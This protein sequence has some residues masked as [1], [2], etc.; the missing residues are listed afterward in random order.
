[1][2]V[3]DYYK[4]LGVSKTASQ[5]EI[6]RAFRKLAR[7]HHPDVNPG[8]LAAEE[9]FKEIN[10]AN[11]VLSDVEKRK[12]YDRFGSQW[13]QYEQTGGQPGDF[14]WSQWTSAR[15]S[16]GGSRTQTRNV[17]AEEFETMFGGQGGVGFSDFFE[18]LF[19]GR[20]ASAGPGYARRETQP[21]PRQGRDVEQPLQVTLSEAFHGGTRKLQFD[22]GRVIE[23][24]IPPG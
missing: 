17:S 13:Q 20:G 10:E 5:D 12:K 23:A 3:K 2:D 16:P 19:G 7:K 9:R 8:D 1:M 18:F 22:D 15:P 4:T 24:D 11:E 6:K 21:R 14:D